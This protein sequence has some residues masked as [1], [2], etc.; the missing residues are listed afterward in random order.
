MLFFTELFIGFLLILVS[1]QDYKYR[2]VTWLVFPLMSIVFLYY[3][4]IKTSFELFLTSSFINFFFVGFQLLS[5]TAYFS[6]KELKLVNIS[7]GYLGLGDILF[8]LNLCLIFSPIN[9]IVFYLGTLILVIILFLLCRIARLGSFEKIP[10]AGIQA[11][12]LLVLLLVTKV[13]TV[14]LTDDL[15]IQRYL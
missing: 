1:Y 15:W 11:L 5:I 7:K 9:F 3:S 13:K 4:L 10:L 8:L 14:S 2:A 12:C 6:I